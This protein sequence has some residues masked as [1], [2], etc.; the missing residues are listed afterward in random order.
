MRPAG[1]VAALA[2]SALALG[3]V[4][5]DRLNAVRIALVGVSAQPSPRTGGVPKVLHRG[6][7]T[8][9]RVRYTVTGRTMRPLTSYARLTLQHGST[10]WRFRSASVTQRG[11][12]TW[13]Y[14]APAPRWFPAGRATLVVEAHLT[15]RGVVE[16]LSQRRYSVTV[17]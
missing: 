14:V 10:R 2:A 12:T 7:N 3:A 15:V 8:R 9:W 11:V 1:P 16:A 13:Q 6:Q 17:R 4:S 5:P